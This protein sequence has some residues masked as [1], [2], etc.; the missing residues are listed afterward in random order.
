MISP[1]QRKI[2]AFPYSKYDALICDGSIRSGKTS[3]M[4]VAYVDWAMDNFDGMRFIIGGKTVESAVRNVVEPFMMMTRTKKK[5]A[6]KWN[7]A[8]HRMTVSLGGKTNY[9]DV[10]GGKD[11]A[12]FML[13]QGFTAAGCFIDEVALCERSFVEQAIARCSVDG[14]RLWFN[15]NPGPPKHW[16]RVEWI[17]QLQRHNALHL[18]F[19]MDDNPSLSPHI[20]ERYER[21]YSGVFKLRYIDG[22][23]VVAEGL[24]YPMWS[25]SYV[26]E[27]EPKLDK[28]G[29]DKR[30]YII[31]IDYGI[32]NPFAAIMLTVSEGK[33]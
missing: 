26:Q 24:V 25:D 17:L 11:K 20:R 9:F 13:V 2:L 29:K 16:F 32:K 31:A 8:K 7:T 28:S 10:F 19:T 18:H 12:S 21:M 6:V 30:Q 3:F 27:L 23:W 1:K 33:L 4:T 5:F 22:L 15:C 14:S